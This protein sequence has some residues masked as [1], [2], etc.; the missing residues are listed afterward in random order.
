MKQGRSQTRQSP[1]LSTRHRRCCSWGKVYGG[2]GVVFGGDGEKNFPKP[3][4][5][6]HI[7]LLSSESPSP[8]FLLARKR[9]FSLPK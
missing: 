2:T 1:A 8:Q 7:V 9:I 6:F 3:V 5:L 4:F